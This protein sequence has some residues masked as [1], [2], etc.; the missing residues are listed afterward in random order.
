MDKQKLVETIKKMNEQT[1]VQR[2][3][4]RVLADK[5]DN[6]YG[7][8]QIAEFEGVLEDITYYAEKIAKQKA[9]TNSL[10]STIDSQN[11]LISKEETRKF[12]ASKS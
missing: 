7:G 2:A 10:K 12:L 11:R 3:R 4:I 5:I 6:E 1:N 8:G 9:K